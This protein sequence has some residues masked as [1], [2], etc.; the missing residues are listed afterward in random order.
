MVK[1]FAKPKSLASLRWSLWQMRLCSEKPPT[2]TAQACFA[3]TVQ[4]A[5]IL[6]TDK[7]N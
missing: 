5:S 3:A 1:A 2:V 4:T 7:Q 6:P